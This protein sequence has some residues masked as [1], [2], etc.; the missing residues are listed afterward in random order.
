MAAVCDLRGRGPA[1]CGFMA[2]RKKIMDME[3]RLCF[4]RSEGHK[5]CRDTEDGSPQI[6]RPTT[7][8]HSRLGLSWSAQHESM[9]N[10]TL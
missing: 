2:S 1:L 3:L 8:S 9:T 10:Q 6:S 4:N 5:Y 7:D